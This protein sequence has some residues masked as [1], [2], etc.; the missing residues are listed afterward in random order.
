[1][2]NKIALS[3]TFL[4]ASLAA[5][6]GQTSKQNFVVSIAKGEGA[7]LALAYEKIHAL[8]NKQKLKIGYGLRATAFRGKNLEFITAPAMLTSGKKSIVALFTNY[9]NEKLDTLTFAN[10]TSIALN[11]AVNVGY[12]ISA[13]LSVGFNIDALGA[14]LGSKENGKFKASDSDAQGKA[15]NG[16]TVSA[17]PTTF[18]ILLI[19]D[20]D[21]GSLNS[22]IYASYQI[23]QR[24]ALRPGLSFQFI[25]R[26]ADRAL[27]FDNE[28]F[29][30]KQL[31]PMLSLAYSI[32]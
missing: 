23:S 11:A 20:S 31:M 15:N 32:K 22:E 12:Q 21:R 3:F 8:G 10:S 27:A 19:S 26:S 4:L 6:I 18:N 7:S 24:L 29:R 30:T 9:K 16:S 2:I 5:I 28:R 13:K 17:K 14:T 1:M 25:E